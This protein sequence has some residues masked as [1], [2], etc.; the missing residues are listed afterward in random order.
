MSG[1]LTGADVSVIEVRGLGKSYNMF[2]RPSDR[3]KQLLMGG[4][5]SYGRQFH[6]LKNVSFSVRAGETL[7][8]VG[9][10][11]SGKSTLL[12]L[13]VGT[14]TPSSGSLVVR[15]RVAALLELGSGFDPEFTGRD[16]V[17]MNG[18]VIGL[19]K[20]EVNERFEDIACFA[21]LGEFM[22]HPVKTYSSGMFVRLAF[23]IAIHTD[24]DILIIDESL[25]VGDEAFQRKCIARIEAFQQKGG[26]LV[27][28]SHSASTVLE[29][30]DRALLLDH[31]ELLFDGTPKL[32]IGYY[33]KLLFTTGPERDVLRNQITANEVE[34]EAVKP[35]VEQMEAAEFD[36]SLQPTSTLEYGTGAAALSDPHITTLDGRRVNVLNRG[37]RYIYHYQVIFNEDCL[38]VRAGNLF[39]TLNGVELGAL[40]SHPRGGGIERVPAGT[41]L[42]FEYPFRCLLQEGVYFL[43]AGVVG[44]R[45][46]EEDFLHRVVDAMMFR[47]RPESMARKLVDGVVDFSV[48]DMPARVIDESDGDYSDE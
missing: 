17:H 9:Q 7:G 35:A 30:C 18:Q 15:G 42:H 8:V 48:G 33:R 36:A 2:D 20:A 45:G 38:K 44:I 6:A 11:G 37:E 41:E 16:N 3:L 40:I 26:T 29:L 14:H 28:V 23:A 25:A 19:S 10:N 43:N 39:K 27:F 5:R 22:D 34:S 12:H 21:D 31:G 32:A 47:V 46:D 13:L 24:P 1:E 4:R